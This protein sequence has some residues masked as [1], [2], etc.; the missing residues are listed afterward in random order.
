MTRTRPP[1][2]SLLRQAGFTLFETISA[3]AVVGTITGIA[4]PTVQELSA[5]QTLSAASMELTAQLMR[6]RNAA[7]ERSGRVTVAANG[8]WQ[9][10]WSVTEARNGK[11]IEAG[12]ALP[13]K[14]VATAAQDSLSFD[15][16]GRVYGGNSTV[17]FELKVQHGSTAM[18][19][20]ITLD[21]GGRPQVAQS[22]CRA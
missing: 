21:L 6:A 2:R 1:F 5:K 9:A 7:V 11:A 22:A 10:G 16:D 14:V 20:C 3:L 17:Q 18:Y 13:A 4:V 15:R 19:R 8:S 12:A